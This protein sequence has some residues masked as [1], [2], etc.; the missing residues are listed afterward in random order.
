[1]LTV[2]LLVDQ[3][4][5]EIKTLFLVFE[6]EMFFHGSRGSFL[7]SVF[8]FFNNMVTEYKKWFFGRFC[9]GMGFIAVPRFVATEKM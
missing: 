5:E 7:L 1:M 8:F 4:K 6:F 2:D 3:L 9:S